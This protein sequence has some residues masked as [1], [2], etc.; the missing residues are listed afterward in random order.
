M[1][2]IMLVHRIDLAR[3]QTLRRALGL[4]A[5]DVEHIVDE[6]L[7]TAPREEVAMMQSLL[8]K[9]EAA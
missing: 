2:D 1:S 4:G 9:W 3:V 7:A 6:L 5:N 8:G